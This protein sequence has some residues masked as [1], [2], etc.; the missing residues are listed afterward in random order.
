MHVCTL[1]AGLCGLECAH[2]C[3][4]LC[5]TPLPVH[6]R[7]SQAW[8]RCWQGLSL[9]EFSVADTMFPFDWGG[10]VPEKNLA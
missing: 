9:T 2:L 4:Q 5:P 3:P 7:L 6:P 1:C 10:G 8:E